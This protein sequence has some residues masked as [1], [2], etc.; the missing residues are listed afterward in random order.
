MLG[1]WSLRSRSI[2][3][4]CLHGWSVY[5]CL[6]YLCIPQV[7]VPT[8][9][10]ARGS[11]HLGHTPCYVLWIVFSVDFY[12]SVSV[13]VW[14]AWE[15]LQCI[16]FPLGCILFPLEGCG[17]A[18]FLLVHRNV[19]SLGYLKWSASACHRTIPWVHRFQCDLLPL[20]G[21]VLL[22]CF[23]V[24]FGV[25]PVFTLVVFGFLVVVVLFPYPVKQGT[26]YWR[27]WW[28]RLCLFLSFSLTMTTAWYRSRYVWFCLLCVGYSLCFRLLV[29]V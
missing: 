23:A 24:S 14:N 16:P 18:H 17:R 11:C 6:F 22:A 2:L 7:S 13:I 5:I 21:N 19:F 10:R 29:L 15:C 3:H 4:P 25:P 1:L 8:C 12:Y 26:G 27:W 9:S 28:G 20:V